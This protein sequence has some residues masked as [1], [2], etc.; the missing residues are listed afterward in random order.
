MRLER[1]NMVSRIQTL[2][3]AGLAL[4]A[5]LPKVACSPSEAY[6]YVSRNKFPTIFYTIGPLV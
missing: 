2:T 1:G 5:S 4:V 3:A 6:D